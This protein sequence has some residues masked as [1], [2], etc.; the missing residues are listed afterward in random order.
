MKPSDVLATTIL[1]GSLIGLA[2][3]V[4]GGLIFGAAGSAGNDLT[5]NLFE[6]ATLFAVGGAFFVV[7]AIAI[8]SVRAIHA[9]TSRGP[10]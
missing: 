10:L 1:G 7:S 9:E 8:P 3:M 5:T 6:G 4:L 2:M